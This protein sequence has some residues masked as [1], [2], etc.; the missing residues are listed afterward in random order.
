VD[1]EA[2]LRRALTERRKWLL[3]PEAKEL[4]KLVGIST[5]RFRVAHTLEE[6]LEA[7]E[8]VGYPVALKVVSPEILHKSDVGGVALNIDGPA[9]LKEA[10]EG[11]MSR[12]REAVPHARVV[13]VLV[14]EMLR[15]TV[16]VIIGLVRDPQF[17]PAVMFGLGGIFVEL[18]GDVSF[19]IAPL[20]K[21]DAREMIS[22]VKAYKLLEGYRGSPRLDI[23]AV[24]ELILKVSELG[25]KYSLIE[26]MDLNPV[27]V[28]EKGVVVADARIA[29]D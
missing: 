7:A 2:L 3:E 24:V 17:G 4:C 16:E 28:Y 29:I 6:A 22:E 26:Q 21:E 19:R 13:G 1:V 12:V 14:E 20:T 8:E 23:D 11:M 5:T 10:Y 25:V 15:P 27:M 18:Y 9:R